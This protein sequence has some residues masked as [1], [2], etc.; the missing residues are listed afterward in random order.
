MFTCSKHGL[1]VPHPV[2][3]RC[4]VCAAESSCTQPT[5]VQQ[6]K[7]AIALVRQAGA[8]H[9]EAAIVYDDLCRHLE[10]IEQRACV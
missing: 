1:I 9:L 6:L 3:Q 7:Q 2:D 10:T 8:V 4:P 5:D